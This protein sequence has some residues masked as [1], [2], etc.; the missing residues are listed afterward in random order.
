MKKFLILSM[1]AFLVF[2]F[3]SWAAATTTI[4][5]YEGHTTDPLLAATFWAIDGDADRQVTIS[6]VNFGALQYK[7]GAIGWMPFFTGFS[8]LIPTIN[9]EMQV[10]LQ[11]VAGGPFGPFAESAASMTYTGK[12]QPSDTGSS[13][14]HTVVANFSPGISINT[15]AGKS[16]S[17]SPSPVP[18]PGAVWLLGAGVVGLVGVRRKMIQG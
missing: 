12:L 16:D 7:Y 4:P 3:T 2:G 1:A 9:G 17:V 11:S 10:F 14:Y 5:Y 13:L 6:S 15:A 8:L 18:L